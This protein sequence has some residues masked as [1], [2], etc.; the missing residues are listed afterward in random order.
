MYCFRKIK[1]RINIFSAKLP[2]ASHRKSKVL[3]FC[4][5]DLKLFS[6][7]LLQR[8]FNI[9][10]WL[11]CLLDRLQQ[12]YHGLFPF[13]FLTIFKCH[14]DLTNVQNLQFF[15]DIIIIIIIIFII[16]LLYNIFVLPCN[17]FSFYKKQQHQQ[18]ISNN[19]SFASV[20]ITD[21]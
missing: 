19:S 3:L 21:C 5:L 17:L 7:T 8:I 11:T 16:I 13:V 2:P 15:C 6:L 1:V 10:N 12:Y 9:G 14:R 4:L 20:L 18:N